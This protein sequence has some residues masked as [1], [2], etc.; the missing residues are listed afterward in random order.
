MWKGV[1][2]RQCKQKYVRSLQVIGNG[3][4]VSL[5]FQESLKKCHYKQ[6]QQM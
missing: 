4:K 5:T 6:N 2:P 1:V 3:E